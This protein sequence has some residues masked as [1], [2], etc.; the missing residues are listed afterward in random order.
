MANK[1]A[2]MLNLTD[3][4]KFE[5]SWLGFQEGSLFWAGGQN[6]FFTLTLY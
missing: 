5:S 6:L 2:K 1:G 3:N 4:Q